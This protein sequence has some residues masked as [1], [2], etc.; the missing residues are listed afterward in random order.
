MDDELP[1]DGKRPKYWPVVEEYGTIQAQLRLIRDG[2]RVLEVGTAAGYATR[3]LKGK[4]CEV[5][6]IELDADLADLA[7]PVCRQ[8]I[9]GDVERL[10]LDEQ[11]PED[12]DVILCGDVLEHM[13]DPGAVLQK[14]KRK[15]TP[16]G[17]MVVCIPN[18][19]HASVRLDLL[20]GNFA[21]KEE[22]LLDATHLRFLTLDSIVALF[23]QNGLE[24]RDLHRV[25]WG[26]FATEIQVVPTQASAFTFRQIIQDPEATT[27]QFVFQAVPS[28]R[29]NSVFDLRDAGF[30]PRNE[31]RAFSRF[32]MA[33]AWAA[34]H[35]ADLVGLEVRAW[36]WLAFV[37]RPTVKAAFYWMLSFSPLRFWK[38]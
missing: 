23:N 11:L 12:F 28:A 30:D 27:Y 1:V 25:R 8:M 7:A 34:L 33:K 17:R 26:P 10:D 6:G 15:L 21:Y 19:A 35:G 37:C 9:V 14:L 31:R 3:A 32:C 18:V 38:A 24:I 4:G 22:G 5:T 36:A 29:A 16:A 20:A 2:S 13:K